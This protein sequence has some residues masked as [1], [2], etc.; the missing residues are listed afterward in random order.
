MSFQEK[1]KHEIKAIAQVTLYFAVWLGLF[2]VIKKLV[3]AEYKIEFS[4]MSQVL[5]GALVLAK[6]VL[7]LEHVSLGEGTRPALVDVILRTVFYTAG[8]FVVLILEKGFEGRHEYGGFG[9]SLTAVFQ[10]ADAYHVWANT[11]CVSGALLAYN[12]MAVIRRHLG[13]G[14]L[15]RLLMAP[16]PEESTAE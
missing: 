6:V 8:V 10:H 9:P 4:G 13:E 16:M 1:L 7:I 12:V 3:L 11:I 2:I 5:I 15:M 14:G